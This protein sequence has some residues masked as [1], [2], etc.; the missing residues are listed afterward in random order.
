MEDAWLMESVPSSRRASTS[1]ITR[2]ANGIGMTVGPILGSYSWSSLGAVT[3]FATAGLIFGIQ[4]IPYLKVK[5]TH[6]I[7]Q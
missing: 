2:M 4:F 3:S 5:E 1:G 6:V 7:N